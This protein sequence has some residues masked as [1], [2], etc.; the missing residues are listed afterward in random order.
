MPPED[1]DGTFQV[2]ERLLLCGGSGYIGQWPRSGR[3]SPFS[4]CL[5]ARSGNERCLP[6]A[7][8]VPEAFRELREQAGASM[9]A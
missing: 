1:S 5:P 7:F 3:T 4:A 9:I 8:H 6:T 2:E